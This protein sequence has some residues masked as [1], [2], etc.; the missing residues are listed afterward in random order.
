MESLAAFEQEV[1]HTK[2]QEARE[3]LNELNFPTSKTEYWKYS[4]T[5]RITNKAWKPGAPDASVQVSKYIPEGYQGLVYT[6]VN[7]HFR[8][9]LSVNKPEEALMTGTLKDA[10]FR[11]PEIFDKYFGQIAHA[12]TDIFSALNTAWQHDG[13]FI[14]V[15]RNLDVERSVMLLHITTGEGVMAQPRNLIVAEQGARLNLIMHYVNEGGSFTNALTEI[16]VG[17]NAMIG[18]DKLQTG[19]A[20]SFQI[21]TEECI[22]KRD[23]NYT[24][25][26]F[27]L[28]GNWI[29][30][31]SNCALDGE[32]IES[33]LNGLYFPDKKEHIDN[34]TII[35]HLKPHC[36][37]NELYKGVL[38]GNSTG[39][40]NGKVFVRPDAQKTNAFQS[41]ANIL[42]SD[43]A[44]IN[45]KPELEIYADDVKCSHGS[46][47]GQL[48]TEALFYLRSRGIGE[49]A[50]RNLLIQ[51]FL[52]D[53]LE[54]AIHEEVKQVVAA[55][56]EETFNW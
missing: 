54:K 36:E 16:S 31:N 12:D 30:N 47:T 51:A 27:T 4:R 28:Q 43:E 29:R 25:N 20:D 7:G 32:N 45:S 35:D 24:L 52:S 48:D 56:I 26:T 19:S 3:A 11:H 34:H 40:F 18:I 9:D 50:A 33:H 38:S 10:A 42:K 1:Y 46:T 22:Q 49:R 41:N 2:I 5:A 14:Y 21:I 15:P 6:F 17:E 55:A 44:T 8:A 37:S 39:V 13:L 53:V 23:S